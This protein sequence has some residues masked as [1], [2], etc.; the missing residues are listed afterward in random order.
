MIAVAV[1]IIVVSVLAWIFVLR[2]LC[3]MTASI[4]AYV[5]QMVELFEGMPG[6]LAALTEDLTAQTR[7]Q[8]VALHD[9]LTKLE[10]AADRSMKAARQLAENL[11]AR[12]EKVDIASAGVAADLSAS[13]QRA[14][15]TMTS[16]AEPG[17][18][19]DAALTMPEEKKDAP[20]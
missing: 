8:G 7:N 2:P 19:A 15:D 12:E 5:K 4:L 6:S 16:G 17:A 11:E 9:V 1:L 20:D 14:T 3:D 18:A 10:L 13:V